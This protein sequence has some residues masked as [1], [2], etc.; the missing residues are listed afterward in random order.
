MDRVHEMQRNE[1]AFRQMEAGLAQAFPAGRFVAISEGRIVADA[2]RLDA[3]RSILQ[4][5][6]KDPRQVLVVRVGDEY[7]Q[8]GI[9]LLDSGKP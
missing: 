4:G 9:I 1:T 6:G 7:P 2:E 3:I 8:S 5:L